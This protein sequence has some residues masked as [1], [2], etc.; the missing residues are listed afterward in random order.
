MELSHYYVSVAAFWPFS[1]PTWCVEHVC[2]STVVCRAWA[3][4]TTVG[5]STSIYISCLAV[6]LLSTPVHLPGRAEKQCQELPCR[7]DG[8]T[9]TSFQILWL[10]GQVPGTSV[11]PLGTKGTSQERLSR[12]WQ[13]ARSQL[14]SWSIVSW[15]ETL[16]TGI[17]RNSI[18]LLIDLK[19]LGNQP[20]LSFALN[21]LSSLLK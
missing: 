9:C 12:P 6:S 16:V 4:G 1:I 17:S 19:S 8:W 5:S 10:K 13:L 18:Y 11:Y 15:K 3:R 2:H 21:T 20:N 14:V 7:E